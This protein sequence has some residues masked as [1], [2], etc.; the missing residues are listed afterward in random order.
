MAQD[1]VGQT[2]L[3]APQEEPLVGKGPIAQALSTRSYDAAVLISDY[4]E[5]EVMPFLEW[6]MS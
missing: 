6:V 1:G 3:R 4:P 2:D 5:K